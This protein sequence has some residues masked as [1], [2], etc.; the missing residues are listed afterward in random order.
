MIHLCEVQNLTKRI[1]GARNEDDDYHWRDR[2]SHLKGSLRSS[3]NALYLGEEV[4]WIFTV[5]IHKPVHLYLCVFL[6]VHYF[7]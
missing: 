4:A 5:K 2:R 3:S 7:Q 1:N 6:S